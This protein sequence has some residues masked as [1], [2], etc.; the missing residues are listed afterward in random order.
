MSF[1]PSLLPP[2][3]EGLGSLVVWIACGLAVYLLAYGEPDWHAAFTYV[4]LV[5]WVFFVL[6][7]IVKWVVIIGLFA[8]ALALVVSYLA[9]LRYE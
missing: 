1:S 2:V 6:W 5:F 9:R 7:W 3:R 4:F 8:L